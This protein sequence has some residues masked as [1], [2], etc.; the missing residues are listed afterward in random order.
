M[1][2]H[3]PQGQLT[4]EQELL[5]KGSSRWACFTCRSTKLRPLI[6]LAKD[7]FP[8][9]DSQ[10]VIT[11]SHDAIFGCDVC[12]HGYVE[13]RRHD[14][15]DFEEV[16]DQDQV[17]ALDGDSIAKVADCLPRCPNPLLETCDCK[18]HQS[19]RS[20]WSWLPRHVW[21]RYTG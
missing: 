12:H 3:F 8:P 2:A 20:S 9:G 10:H 4:P 15:F 18:V 7:G 14:C 5:V 6:V 21:D 19:L 13:L 11:Y 16:F 1:T 17:C